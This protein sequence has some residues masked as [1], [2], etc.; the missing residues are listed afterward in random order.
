MRETDP[1]QA[2]ISDPALPAIAR[3]DPL[4]DAYPPENYR[5]LAAEYPWLAIA[6]GA[7]IGLL[8]G[9]LLPAK[10]GAKLGKRAL[11][12]ATMAGE[13]GLTLSARAREKS[14]PAREWT[15]QTGRDGLARITDGTGEL[16][17]RAKRSAASAK[18]MGGA[19][20]L[21]AIKLIAKA[22]K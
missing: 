2:E 9:A 8:V 18:S 5:S 3:R 21:E 11:G 17:D 15:T 12:M 20:A 6:A 7:G 10:A 14:A 1:R 4:P 13:L 22:R 16:R 19:L